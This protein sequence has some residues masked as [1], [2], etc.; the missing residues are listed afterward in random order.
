[1]RWRPEGLF[2]LFNSDNNHA[3]TNGKVNH[4]TENE[5]PQELGVSLG[6]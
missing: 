6:K 3:L 2:D 5:K 1:M 4:I